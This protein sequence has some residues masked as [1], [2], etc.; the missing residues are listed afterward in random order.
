[1]TEYTRRRTLTAPA[2]FNPVEAPTKNPSSWS[3]R[4][5]YNRKHK[6]VDK[7]TTD[8]MKHEYISAMRAM[9]HL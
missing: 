9:T 3:K 5:V 2:T 7:T 8:H 1:M 4:K 6:R